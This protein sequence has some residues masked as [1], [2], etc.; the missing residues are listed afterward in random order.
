MPDGSTL[1]GWPRGMKE[2]HAAAY[3]GLS[4]TTFRQVVVPA[5][6]AIRV[7]PGRIVWLREDLDAW[8][9]AR[10]G[11]RPVDAPAAGGDAAPQ[12]A[13]H[14]RDPIAAGLANLAA[15]RRPGRPHKAG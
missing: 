10:A 6:P 7:T 2:T 1:P 13:T 3:L 9:D 11:R 14:A 15:A 12:E 5:V 8:L 4:T